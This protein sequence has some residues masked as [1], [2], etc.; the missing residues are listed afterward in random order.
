MP[1]R[2]GERHSR[3]IAFEASIVRAEDAFIVSFVSSWKWCEQENARRKLILKG[4]RDRL[5]LNEFKEA[6]SD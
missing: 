1:T 6:K 5:F 3:K 2:E 4:G